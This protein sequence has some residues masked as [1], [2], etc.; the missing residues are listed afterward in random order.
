MSFERNIYIYIK[1][2]VTGYYEKKGFNMIWAVFNNEIFYRI[3][4]AKKNKGKRICET[5]KNS[6]AIYEYLFN[7]AK[8]VKNFF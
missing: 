7:F 1:E 6:Y 2:A 3:I 4:Q 8:S 5:P